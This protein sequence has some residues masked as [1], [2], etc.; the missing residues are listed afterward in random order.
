MPNTIIPEDFPYDIINRGRQDSER[1]SRRV[2]DAAK[3]QLKDIISQQDIITT[4][5]NK[6]VK[7]RLKNLDQ[8]HFIYNRDRVD[9]IGR[10]EFDELSPGETIYRPSSGSA[11]KRA[12]NDSGDII[13]EA[14]FSIDEI[15]Q[16]LIA[17]F[18]LPDLDER[19]RTEI[20]SDVIEWSDRVKGRGIEACVDKKKTILSHILRRKKMRR[21]TGVP[22]IKDD[23]QY[24]TWQISTEKH[25]NAVIF[26]MMDRSGSMGEDKIYLVKAFYFWVVRFLKTKYAQV[27]IKFIAHDYDARELT[28]TEFFSIADSGG[29]RVSSAYQLCRDIIKFNYPRDIW[30]IYAFH[31]SDGDS[32]ND[33]QECVRLVENII[34]LGASMFGYSE[35]RTEAQTGPHPER[36]TLYELLEDLSCQNKAVLV[37]MLKD[38]DDVVVTLRKF[39]QQS[40]RKTEELVHS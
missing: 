34:S 21:N 13:Y 38:S 24:R 14:E 2:K 15:T 12:G 17:E 8:Y 23:I 30:N 11:G 31:A 9:Q 6:K 36:S 1:H 5:G 39:F 35:V 27:H 4:E 22:I 19:N 32:W 33:E 25:S 28:E 18:Q 20:I 29:T 16:M 7:V 10:D 37:S 40:H 3:K 26:L